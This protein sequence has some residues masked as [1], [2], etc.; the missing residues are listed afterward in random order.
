MQGWRRTVAKYCSV[1]DG[2]KG[3]GTLG[4]SRKVAAWGGRTSV[5]MRVKSI[6]SEG[7]KC[8]TASRLSKALVDASR[9]SSSP[10][11]SHPKFVAGLSTQA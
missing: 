1:V 5:G 2:L 6:V 11:I 9:E 4:S 7:R 3:F 8:N 10:R